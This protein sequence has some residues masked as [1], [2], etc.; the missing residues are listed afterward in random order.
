ML[1]ILENQACMQP[2][3]V[4]VH[5][6]IWGTSGDQW[7]ATTSLVHACSIWRS[8]RMFHANLNTGRWLEHTIVML[9]H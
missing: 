4:G 9:H 8:D 1:P 3:E 6:Y 5:V 7:G 2:D